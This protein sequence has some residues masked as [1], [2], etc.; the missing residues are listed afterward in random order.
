[1]DVDSLTLRATTAYHR[2]GEPRSV[3]DPKNTDPNGD[4][5]AS[6]DDDELSISDRA[7]R[8]LAIEDEST[9]GDTPPDGESRTQRELEARDREVRQ[10]EAAHA[11]AAG[12]LAIGGPTYQYQT[13]PDGQ[14]YAVGGE[15]KIQLR[16][17]TTPEETIRNMERAKRAALA[18]QS[19]SPQ[20]YAVAAEASRLA[21]EARREA[22]EDD[23][24]ENS[25]DRRT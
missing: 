9:T 24:P 15:V 3:D 2:I 8:L 21:A 17:G 25:V 20:D 14:R 6:A 7:R 1:M 16:E 10:H 12:N 13:G 11:A 23:E 18:P 5:F 22:G 4:P 19:P